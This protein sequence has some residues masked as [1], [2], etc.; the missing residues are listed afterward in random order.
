MVKKLLSLVLRRMLS[1]P[2]K[3]KKTTTMKLKR[4][5]MLKKSNQTAKMK[6]SSRK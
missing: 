6:K 3:S 2:Q 5:V 1:L 4:M